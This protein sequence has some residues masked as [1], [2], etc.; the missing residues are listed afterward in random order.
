MSREIA[1]PPTSATQHKR[2]PSSKTGT[3]PPSSTTVISLFTTNLRLLNLDLLPDWPGITTATFAGSQ[4]ARARIR[5]TEF[6]LYQLFRLYDHVTTADKLQPFFP[7]LEPLQSLNLRAGLY[8]C[9][10][11]LKKNGVLGKETVLRKTMLDECC[12]DLFW[13]LCLGFSAVVLRKVTLERKG[14]DGRDGRPV[15]EELGVKLRLGK[16]EVGS[17][18]PLA[19]AHRVSLK[20]V[21]EAKRRKRETF[22]R[23]YDILTE[24]EAELVRRKNR[25][26]DLARSRPSTRQVERLE[27]VEL[28]LRKNWIGSVEVQ[29]VLINGDAAGLGDAVLTKPLSE[30]AKTSAASS[31]PAALEHGLLE[32]LAHSASKQSHRLRRWQTMHEELLASR[33][34]STQIKTSADTT[35]PQSALRFD[36]HRS[37]S[38]REAPPMPPKPP[39]RQRSESQASSVT[40]YDDLLTAMREELRQGRRANSPAKPAAR[41]PASVH[42]D[43]AAGALDPHPH[44]RSPSQHQT[45]TVPILRPAMNRRVSSRSKSYQQPKVES[46]R[47]PIPLKSEIFSPL[48]THRNSSS[49]PLS[50]SSLVASPVSEGGG[51]ASP[52]LGLGGRV[53]RPVS[54]SSEANGKAD[55]G[56]GLGISTT[57][58]TR[59]R[60]PSP[61][62]MDDVGAVPERTFKVPAVPE[63]MHDPAKGVV[64]PSLA[65]RTRMSMAV[66]S[67][68]EVGGFLPEPPGASGAASAPVT[69]TTDDSPTSGEGAEAESQGTL[70]S[71]LGRTRPSEEAKS[72]NNPPTTLLDR[73]RHSI[74]LHQPPAAPQPTKENPANM[75]H[76]RNRSSIIYPINHFDTPQ[77]KK[78]RRS[79]LAVEGQPRS[80]GKKRD[81]TPREQLFSPDAQYDSIFKPRPKVKMSPVMSP[82]GGGGDVGGSPSMLD[83]VGR[84]SPLVGVGGRR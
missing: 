44:P 8:R 60:Q 71:P 56:V 74:S 9:L 16:G 12:G 73:T 50:S 29:G 58:P 66:Q 32:T 79:S 55:G 24:K 81:I 84:G 47:Q 6:A 36:K 45:T 34:A 21:L 53:R 40:R 19:V 62:A 69:R 65:E 72:H 11:E 48:K 17:L 63:R 77:Q 64:R 67:G 26:Q 15:A 1:P 78:P 38:I 57:P 75:G 33:Q 3:R 49:S 22:A 25:A 4:D 5:C 20:G 31:P 7:P 39:L 37:L 80:V 28:G 83:E 13:Q 41:R 70:T 52:G 43:T 76:S 51:G 61:S 23:L 42:I 27:A 35:K 10:N 14:R 59:E 2:T 68:E 82:N 18:L 46:Q 30:L 54:Q